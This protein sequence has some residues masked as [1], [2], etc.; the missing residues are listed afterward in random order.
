MPVVLWILQR[1]CCQTLLLVATHSYFQPCVDIGVDA[2]ELR[3][4]EV[5]ISEF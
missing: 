5:E 1:K 4:V 2:F 3:A